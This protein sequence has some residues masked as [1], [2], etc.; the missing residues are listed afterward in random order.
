M[1]SDS[2]DLASPE[3]NPRQ[4]F[5]CKQFIW[6][7]IPGSTRKG[8]GG[9]A[10]KL[11]NP[12]CVTEPVPPMGNLGLGP[13]GNSWSCLKTCLTGSF[14]S[15]EGCLCSNFCNPLAEGCSG[16]TC[17]GWARLE[18]PWLESGCWWSQAGYPPGKRTWWR[19]QGGLD[20]ALS[21][22]SPNRQGFTQA[23]SSLSD[24]C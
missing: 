20:S 16:G 23:E 14:H 7:E 22:S 10:R 21:C 17:P 1:I 2:F 13:G 4:G 15:S 6:D 5:G 12:I 9:R 11:E 19:A 18:S 3:Q 8:E 24:F